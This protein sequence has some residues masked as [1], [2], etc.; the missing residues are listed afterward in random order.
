LPVS[1]RRFNDKGSLHYILGRGVDFTLKKDIQGWLEDKLPNLTDPKLPKIHIQPIPL[2]PRES[3]VP[4][5]IYIPPS[6]EAPHQAQEH[7]FYTRIS[8]KTPP[9]LNA[10]CL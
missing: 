6:S 9:A 3:K 4:L 10:D 7:K 2:S 1:G 8:D 5:V